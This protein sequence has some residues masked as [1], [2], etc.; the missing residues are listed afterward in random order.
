MNVLV[1]GA[2]I[3]G[4]SIAQD[5]AAHATQPLYTI[6]VLNSWKQPRDLL[7]AMWNCWYQ[8][9]SMMNRMPKM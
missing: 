3:M 7:P 5:F 2:G 4:H 8:N 1:I 9:L 6:K